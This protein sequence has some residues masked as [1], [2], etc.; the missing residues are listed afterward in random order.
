MAGARQNTTCPYL[1]LSYDRETWLAFPSDG[2]HCHHAKPPGAIRL[3]HQEECCLTSEFLGCPVLDQPKGKPLPPELRLDVAEPRSIPIPLPLLLLG[4]V[5]LGAVILFGL[6][7]FME[8]PGQE[9]VVAVVADVTET[10]TTAAEAAVANEPQS[11]GNAIVATET[12]AAMATPVA[13]PTSLPTATASP[14]ET[15]SPTPTATEALPSP[16]PEAPQ[17]LVI[18]ARLNVRAGPGTNYPV[19]GQVDEG[20]SLSI[21]GRDRSGDWWQVCCVAGEEG[22]IFSET[23]T[24]QG[25]VSGIPV[26]PAP[27]TPV[28]TP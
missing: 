3:S 17:A 4:V 8:N 23:V 24:V 27:P 18:V 28:P 20:E 16:T 5:F 7:R 2:N 22:W 1:G 19:L 12:P 9:P 13:T 11:A 26:I 10:A 25:D 21:S 6:W 14:T 15:P